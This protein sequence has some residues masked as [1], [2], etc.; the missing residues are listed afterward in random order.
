MHHVILYLVPPSGAAA[1]LAAD[2]ATPEPGYK[3]F[4]SSGHGGQPMGVGVWGAGGP[5]DAVPG[6]IPRSVLEAGARGT[7]AQ[8]CT[9]TPPA[10]RRART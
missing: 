5:A 9:T 7:V 4:G 2:A 6:Q 10:A 3:C 1:M 8:E